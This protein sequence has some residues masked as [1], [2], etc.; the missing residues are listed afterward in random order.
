MELPEVSITHFLVSAFH[1]SS[2]LLCK[3]LRR[4]QHSLDT[5]MSVTLSTPV[6]PQIQLKYFTKTQMPF[7]ATR[8]KFWHPPT[9]HS[10]KTF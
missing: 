6:L 4:C 3:D 1:R 2:E 7:S 5:G 8:N 9:S 10:W